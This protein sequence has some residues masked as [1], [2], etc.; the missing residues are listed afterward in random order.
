VHLA[1]IHACTCYN[2]WDEQ[3]KFAHL[4]ASL[5]QGAAQCLW[6]VNSSTNQNLD[7]LINLLKSRFGSEDQAEKLRMEIKLRRRRAGE[8][9]QVLYQEIKR[10]MALA[11]PGPS[12]PTTDIVSRDAFLD[13]LDDKLTSNRF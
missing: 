9:L 5:V 11:Y 13:A 3:D 6:Y 12:N 1:K 7:Q 8:S 2:A 4:Q 10:S